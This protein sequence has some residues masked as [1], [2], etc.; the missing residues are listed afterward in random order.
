[1]VWSAD[2]IEPN[3]QRPNM[4]LTFH[5]NL[6]SAPAGRQTDYLVISGE[7]HVSRIYKRDSADGANSQ[8]LWAINGVQRAAPDVM[9]LAGIAAALDEAKAELQEN[10]E[11][12]LAWANLREDPTPS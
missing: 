5:L 8:W 4:P 12:W 3:N 9:C 11:K 2:A 1:M 6:D 10:W 7:L